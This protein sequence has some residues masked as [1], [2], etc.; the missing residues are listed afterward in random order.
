V[1]LARPRNFAG[2]HLQ[3]V[4]F[5]ADFGFGDTIKKLADARVRAGL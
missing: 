5:L 1:S 4:D 3:V 2:Q